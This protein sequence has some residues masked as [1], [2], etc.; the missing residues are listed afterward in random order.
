M[1]VRISASHLLDGRFD[2]YDSVF[3]ILDEEDRFEGETM[4]L[5]RTLCASI[6]FHGSHPEAPPQYEKLM[7]YIRKN[8]LKVTGFSREITIVDYGLTN[9]MEQFVTEIRI[10]GA[11]N[12]A[13]SR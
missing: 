12:P 11:E 13:Q 6:R 10:P 8:H 5:P 7:D 3:L 1:G 2:Q 4:Q 9:D